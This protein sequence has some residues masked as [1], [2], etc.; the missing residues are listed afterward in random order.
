[1]SVAAGIDTIG[2]AIL[3]KPPASAKR[4][5]HHLD[6]PVRE[7]LAMAMAADVLAAVKASGAFDTVLL[8]GSAEA[9]AGLARTHGAILVAEPSPQGLDRAA[10]RAM[11][12][13]AERG[14][15]WGTLFPGDIPLADAA[16]I[17]C[18]TRGLLGAMRDQAGVR[19]IVPCRHDDGTNMLI[20][21]AAGGPGFS[22]GRGSFRRHCAGAARAHVRWD[23][24]IALDI[25]EPA[26]LAELARRVAGMDLPP[27]RTAQWLAMYATQ[28]IAA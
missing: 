4:R 7:R 24:R 18:V 6:P 17:A 21:E 5:L 16:T 1:M 22:Y 26:D 15:R 11:R 8:V 23:D 12:A 10:A 27:P 3:L 25:D 14:V 19:G 28:A 13:L 9:H 2:A 20:C